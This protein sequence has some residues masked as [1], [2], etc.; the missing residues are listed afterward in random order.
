MEI[1]EWQLSMNFNKFPDFTFNLMIL[2]HITG[3]GNDFMS[4]QP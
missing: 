3:I 1:P 2:L 4:K